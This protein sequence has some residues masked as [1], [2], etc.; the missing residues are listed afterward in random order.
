MKK[1]QVKYLPKGEMKKRQVKYP[2]RGN[3]KAA[4]ELPVKGK[5][6]KQQADACN[7]CDQ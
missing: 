6:K 4:G 5:M 2:K 1:R 7:L 3:E